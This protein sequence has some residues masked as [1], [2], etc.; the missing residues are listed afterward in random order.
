MIITITIISNIIIITIHIII[1]YSAFLRIRVD[2][3]Q[4]LGFLFQV[5]D[6]PKSASKTA[7]RDGSSQ[8]QHKAMFKG[9]TIVTVPKPLQNL[10]EPVQTLVEPL[11]MNV[12]TA[13]VNS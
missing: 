13:K 4:Q 10:I 6:R 11:V 1:R 5:P 9:G 3:V 2:R 8:C 7:E 12:R